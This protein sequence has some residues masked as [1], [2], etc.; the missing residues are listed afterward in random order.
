MPEKTNSESDVNPLENAVGSSSEVDLLFYPADYI[1]VTARRGQDFLL[2]DTSSGFTPESVARGVGFRLIVDVPAVSGVSTL[3][4]NV[5]TYRTWVAIESSN[6]KLNQDASPVSSSYF[7]EEDPS[8]GELYQGND[9]SFSMNTDSENE[10]L[11]Q[12]TSTAPLGQYTIF[13]RV[14][15]GTNTYAFLFPYQLTA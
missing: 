6:L 4:F 1:I 2:L 12:H 15:S 10:I 3:N 5:K 13:G 8:L 11:F 9:S 14:V 7:E